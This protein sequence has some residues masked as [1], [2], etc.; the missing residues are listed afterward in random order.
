MPKGPHEYTHNDYG[1]TH[2]NFLR[3]KQNMAM[4][5]VIANYDFAAE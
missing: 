3:F 5:C 2:T 4:F 1:K